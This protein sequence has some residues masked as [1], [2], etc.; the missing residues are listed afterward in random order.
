MGERLTQAPGKTGY[1]NSFETNF[2]VVSSLIYGENSN[3]LGLYAAA[4]CY[5]VVHVASWPSHFDLDMDIHRINHMVT[6]SADYMLKVFLVNSVTWISDEYIARMSHN[7]Q[8]RDFLTAGKTRKMGA[9]VMNPFG[10]IIACGDG[11]P[12]KLLLCDVKLEDMVIPHA[13]QDS[14]EHYQRPELFAPLFKPYF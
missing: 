14:S 2:V 3:P 11:E 7:Q 12:S 8:I 4:T 1:T 5:P 10:E 13:F 6:V 9:T